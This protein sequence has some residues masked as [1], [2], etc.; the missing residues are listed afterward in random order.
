MYF[1]IFSFF[2]SF[3]I[4]LTGQRVL[5]SLLSFLDYHWL[6][7]IE[8]LILPL[9]FMAFALYF[10]ELFHVIWFKK[11]YRALLIISA[12][13]SLIILFFPLNIYGVVFPVFQVSAFLFGIVIA[14]AAFISYKQKTEGS[15][16]FL[17]GFLLILI[18]GIND[19]LV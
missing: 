6:L 4:L 16:I 13:I 8:F 3:R 15:L 1:G 9:A 19:I 11:F 7:K 5:Y 17:F 2:F 14:V 18:C 12:L 10:Q